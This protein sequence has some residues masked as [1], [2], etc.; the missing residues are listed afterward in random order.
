M[1]SFEQYA[2][3]IP[4]GTAIAQSWNPLLAER[5]GDIVGSEMERFGIHLWLAQLLTS[6]GPY[7]AAGIMN[8]FQ[9]TR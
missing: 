8:I 4:I 5:C 7:D 9:K 2:T 6:I 3:A 1:R